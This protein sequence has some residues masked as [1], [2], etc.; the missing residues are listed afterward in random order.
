MLD[1]TSSTQMPSASAPP[2]CKPGWPPSSPSLSSTLPGP[3]SFPLP[4]AAKVAAGDAA[5]PPLSKHFKCASGKQR[6]H[7]PLSLGVLFLV[8]LRCG[9]SSLPFLTPSWVS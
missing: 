9:I 7:A 8:S 1:P 3:P 2:L 4:S 5:V 6:N